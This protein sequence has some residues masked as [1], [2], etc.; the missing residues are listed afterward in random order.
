MKKILLSLAQLFIFVV[1]CNV[2]FAQNAW[3]VPRLANGKP[4]LQGHW[5]NGTISTLERNPSFGEQLLLTE[6]EATAIE[7]S[8]FL[9]RMAAGDAVPSDPNRSAPEA[10]RDP[11]AYNAFWLEP[12]T[13]VMR[14]DGE[15]RSSFI[16]EPSN[17]RIPY[18][19][20]GEQAW[21]RYNASIGFNGPEHR[22][23]EERC[24]VGYGSG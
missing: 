22:P 4:D 13:S 17:G 11:G 14:I 9:N 23:L 19:E 15:A 12:G 8:N 2:S 10:G 6:E 5:T 18:T 16:I 24:I 3:E 1:C 7:Q 20:Q 21:D